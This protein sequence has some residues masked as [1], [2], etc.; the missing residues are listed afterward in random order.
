MLRGGVI[1]L[2]ALFS[3]LFLK[4]TL[5]SHHYL[6]MFLVITGVT[7]VGLSAILDS[8]NEN[9]SGSQILGVILIASSLVLQAGL[10]VSEEIIFKHRHFEPMECVGGEGVFYII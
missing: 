9:E 10:F 6:G 5:Y 2:V 3:V 4:R 1:V 8:S 7:M